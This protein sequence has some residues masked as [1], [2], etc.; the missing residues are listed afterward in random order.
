[1]PDRD[2]QSSRGLLRPGERD[3]V[4]CFRFIAAEQAHHPVARLCRA[5][6]VSRS[7]FYAW[8]SRPP[9]AHAVRDAA[10]TGLIRQIHRRSHT[11][12]GA[13]RVHA[14]LRQAHHQRCA[15]KRVA[16]LMRQAGVEGCHRRRF[17]RTTKREPMAASAPDRLTRPF[18]AD[19]P[20]CVWVADLTFVPLSHR[21]AYL[22]VV[23]DVFSRK[24]VG[25]AIADHLRS[26][27]VIAALDL[28]LARRGTV[29]GVVHHSDHGSQYTGL[30]F[31]QRC[32]EASIVP[33]MGAVGDCYDNALAE[34]FFA[35]LETELIATSRWHT[36]AEARSAIFTFIETFYNPPRRHS[37]LGYLSPNAFEKEYERQTHERQQLAS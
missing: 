4:S 12:Y 29:A 24:V 23:V 16:R 1:V 2:F 34:S 21:F 26:D 3:P 22:A 17:M 8:R 15:R 37:S 10:L 7:G 30:A 36:L 31:G 13:P 5:L 35:T 32:R 9:S 6:G 28:A 19:A 20:D 11:T 27:L 14:E 33:S 25:W 18:H